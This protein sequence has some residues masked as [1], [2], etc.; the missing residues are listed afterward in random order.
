VPGGHPP[1]IRAAGGPAACAAPPAMPMRKCPLFWH[2]FAGL[3]LVALA[4]QAVLAS[5]LLFQQRT[6]ALEEQHRHLEA[7]ANWAVERVLPHLGT[8]ASL[9]LAEACRVFDRQTGARVTVIHSNGVVWA[10]SRRD[11]HD[12]DLHA[13]RPEVMAALAGPSGFARRF[14]Q[15]T[16]VRM[17][18]LAHRVPSPDGADVVV[19]VA[20]PERSV[21]LSLRPLR[22]RAVAAW[23]LLLVLVVLVSLVLSRRLS[24]PLEELR[25]VARQLAAGGRPEAWPEASTRET[26]TLSEAMRDMASGLQDKLSTIELLLEEQR[27]VFDSMADGVLVVDPEERVLD[28][29]RAAATLL[30]LTGDGVRGRPLLEVARSARLNELVRASLQGAA[31]VVGDLTLYGPQ[32]RFLQVRGT[33]LRA[34]ARATGALLVLTDVTRLREL[35]TM[36]RDFVA[37]ASHEL[38]TPVTAIKG[39]AETLAEGALEPEQARRFT[40]TIARQADQLGALVDDLLE[41][42]RLEHARDRGALDRQEVAL[43]GIVWSAVELCADEALQKD[44]KLTVRCPEGLL[45]Q[46][47]PMLWQRAIVNLIDNAVKYSGGHTEVVIQAERDAKETRVFVSDQGCGIPAEHLA[48][49]FERFYRV[50]KSRSRKLGGTGLGLSIVKHVAQSHGGD[51]TVTSTPGQG[52]TFILHLPLP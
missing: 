43:A 48:R 24:R 36:R 52:S 16:G 19:R 18:Y 50:D 28:L 40:K 13:G 10:D 6:Y 4:G 44:I 20:V 30:G 46:V 11:V 21:L 45:V 27:A 3:V 12:M 31:P 9:E 32:E 14:S 17:L 22:D 38:K 42:T 51:V 26:A 41:L 1:Y 29:N 47:D 15:S 7:I 23:L 35:E 34:G 39:F 49:I 5:Y 2:I 8:S 37:N 25:E 33:T